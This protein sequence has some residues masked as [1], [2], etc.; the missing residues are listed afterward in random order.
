MFFGL[1][2]YIVAIAAGF[3]LEKL[4]ASDALLVTL[5]VGSLIGLVWLF[6]WQPFTLWATGILAVSGLIILSVSVG[7]FRPYRLP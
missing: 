3:R 6:R 5:S 2:I 4:D 7:N 1:A